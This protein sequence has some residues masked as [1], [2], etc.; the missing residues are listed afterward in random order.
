MKVSFLLS[1]AL[2]V[3]TFIA[4]LIVWGVL[5][6]AGLWESINEILA[7]FSSETGPPLDVRDYIGAGRVLGFTLVVSVL[8]VILL[9]ALA[10]LGAFVYNLSAALLGGVQ[11]TLTE[12]DHR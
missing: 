12:E 4:V 1:V 10:T 11:V 6:A 5:S 7:P 8:D 9:T 3:V 2:G